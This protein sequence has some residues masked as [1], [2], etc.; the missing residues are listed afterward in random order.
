MQDVNQIPIRLIKQITRPS[1][2]S[3]YDSRTGH[4]ATPHGSD[5]ESTRTDSRGLRRPAVIKQ[6]GYMLYASKSSARLRAD[7]DQLPY[8]ISRDAPGRCSRRTQTVRPALRLRRLADGA[9]PPGSQAFLHVTD[10]FSPYNSDDR[11]AELARSA[12]AKI[13]SAAAAQL[14]QPDPRR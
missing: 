8:Y 6:H 3:T 12:L 11:L 1:P 7:T 13:H 2:L 9:L 10:L 5:G 4:D 14:T